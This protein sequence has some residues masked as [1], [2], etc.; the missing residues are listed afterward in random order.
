MDFDD[1]HGVH[2]VDETK[3]AG[4]AVG[5]TSGDWVKFAG[6]SLGSGATTFTARTAASAAGT[7]EVRLDSPTGPLAGTAPVA[8]TAD[9]YTYAT[10][11]A[12]LHGATGHHD[13]YLVFRGDLRLSTF[14]LR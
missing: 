14:S 3:V 8:P 11:T 5:A 2:L 13:V 1:Y 9:K 4:D 12:A 10:T 7:V 6:A